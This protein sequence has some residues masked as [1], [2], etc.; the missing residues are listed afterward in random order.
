MTEH[1]DAS[2]ALFR[3]EDPDQARAR[4]EHVALRHLAER[5]AAAREPGASGA[6]GGLT[7]QEAI[8]LVASRAAG[9]GRSEAA[10]EVEQLDVMAALTLIARA[11]ADL[12][13]L[14]ASLMFVARDLGLTWQDIAYDLGLRSAQAAQQRAGRSRQGSGAGRRP[15]RAGSPASP[16]T[17]AASDL[18]GEREQ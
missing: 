1:A 13:V 11:R 9:N 15:G 16:T 7:A 8:H 12:D 10:P 14:E 4:R 17:S 2:E 5:F 3:A 6:P 18:K